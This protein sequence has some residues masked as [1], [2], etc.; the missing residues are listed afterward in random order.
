MAL[1]EK[2]K[3]LRNAYQRAYR[4]RNPEKL[5]LYT[6]RYWERKAASYTPEMKARE[7]HAQG[8]TQREIAGE[9]GVSVGTVNKYLRSDED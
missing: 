1:S 7:L 9:L 6:D 3:E 2:A 8:L 4:L 5:K